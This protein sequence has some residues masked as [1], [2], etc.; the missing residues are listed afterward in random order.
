MILV[1]AEKPSVAAEIAKVIGAGKRGKGYHEGNG[2]L[3]SWC[4]GHLVELAMPEEYGIKKWSLDT[5]PIIPDPY[6]TII[7]EKTADQFR[8]LQE[9]ISRPDVTGLV[10]ATDA[11]REGE[12]IFRLVYAYAPQKKPF[13]RLWL[14]SMEES[15]I[16]EGFHNLKPGKTYDTLYEAA[17]CRAKADWLV[18]INLTRLYT[19]LYS[20]KLTC[21]RVQTPTVNLIVQRQRNIDEFILQTYYSLVAVLGACKAY[22]KADTE[23]EA[24]RIVER[25]DGGTAYVTSVQKQNKKENPEALYDLTMLQRQANMLLGY[26]A[27]QT[28]DCAQSLY[29]KKLIS[30]PRTDSRYLTSDMAETAQAVID[31][32]INHLNVITSNSYNVKMADVKQLINDKKVTDHHAIIPTRSCRQEAIDALP[33]AERNIFY[34]IACRLLSAAYLPY[35]YS[36]TKATFDIEGEEFVA[37]G[38]E[39]KELGYRGIEEQAKALIAAK[40]EKEEDEPDNPDNAGLPPMAKGDAFPDAKVT[41]EPKKTKPPKPY[42]EDTLLKAME[43]AGKDISD[44]ELKEAMKGKGLGTPAT[45]AGIIENIIKTG[46]VERKGKKLLPTEMAYQFIDV[47]DDAVKAPEMTAEW[48]KKLTDISKGEKA[49]KD[50]M[51][52]VEGFVKGLVDR[53]RQ[54]PDTTGRAAMFTT[55]KES[56]GI[57]PACGKPVI[58]NKLSF[59][60]AGWKEG[61][62]FT[63]WKTIAG[64]QIT[65]AQAK[66]LLAKGKTGEIKGFTNK[67]G[68]AFDACLEMKKDQTI[69]FAFAARK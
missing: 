1:I 64:K 2:Y 39:I 44:D 58:E 15:S 33:T 21:G 25:C 8:L 29:E 13:Q 10:E 3:V 11:G 27:M 37:T 40:E 4:V 46:Y 19:K 66:K 14:S 6:K 31:L 23:E 35:T 62:K 12:L 32:T 67:K 9:L 34:L 60:C 50:F 56:I 7:S 57:C 61:C 53:M 26:S 42:T 28:L 5:L 48:E 45:M 54:A 18:G 49:A 24:R 63:I 52:E 22:A 65:K 51:T 59:S 41:A 38:K 16:L 17:Y 55:P 47:V 43:T 30:Y 20:I 68:E 69:G 36:A